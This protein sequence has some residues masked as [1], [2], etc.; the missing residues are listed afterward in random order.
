MSIYS[1]LK[2]LYRRIVPEKTR[3]AVHSSNSFVFRF[4]R[5][6]RKWMQRRASH[7]DLYGK[8]FYESGR[9]DYTSEAAKFVCSFMA[10]TFSPEKFFDAGCGTGEYITEMSN[11]GVACRGVELAEYA[12]AKCRENGLEVESH[13]LTAPG[14]LPDKADLVMCIEVAEHIPESTSDTLVSKLSGAA[15]NTLVFT[16]AVPGQEGS[17]HINLQHP[18]FWIEKFKAKGLTYDAELTDRWRAKNSDAGMP[19]WWCRNLLVFH[20]NA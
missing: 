9:A 16:A 4:A 12:V 2:P 10:E 15:T 1:R 13:D 20:V 17:N 18:S 8:D 14:P 19:E 7:E 11:H 6:A 3:S 5:S